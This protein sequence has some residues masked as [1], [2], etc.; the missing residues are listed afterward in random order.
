M[1]RDY[2]APVKL[3]Y[4]AQIYQVNAYTSMEQFDLAIEKL[5]SML[6]ESRYMDYFSQIEARIGD[7]YVNQN[8]NDFAARQY[9]FVLETYPKTEGS[10][11]AAFG[12]AQ[13]MEFYYQDPDSA[14][15]L[16][17][18]VQKEF[19]KTETV[20][21]AMQRAKVLQSYLKIRDNIKR[22]LADL[23]KL[24]A[25]EEVEM[26]IEE[27]TD[28]LSTDTLSTESVQE[29]LEEETKN[30][31]SSRSKRG[32]QAK[33]PPPAKKRTQEEVVQS[34]EKNRFS[35]AEYFL[36]NMQNY[37]SAEVAYIDFISATQDTVL[38]PKAYHTLYYIYLYQWEDYN[39]ADSLENI[40]LKQYPNSVYA[41]H[42]R[43]KKGNIIAVEEESNPYHE[44]YLEA[45]LRLFAD[46]FEDALN[47]Y[48]QIALEDSGSFWAERSRFAIAWIYEMKLKDVPKAIDAYA[49]IVKEYPN[50]EI[51]KIASNKI[52]EP[53]KDIE[54]NEDEGTTETDSTE[55]VNDIEQGGEDE[56]A[57]SDSTL[58][59]M[60]QNDSTEINQDTPQ[61]NNISPEKKN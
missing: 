40:I 17:L 44:L 52:K 60:E 5:Q 31:R 13:L 36:L 26:E 29:N 28:T 61:E 55:I 32:V 50:T 7:N 3:E 8:D 33:K 41:N 48:Y 22:D 18:R 39:K 25:G 35:L 19:R 46:N 16:Y 15:K 54:P 51:A 6:R 12:L 1:I 2:D 4:D 23:R 9:N 14:R 11:Q 59:I 43:E 57:K 58:I 56:S 45:E 47:I 38:K 24:E 27:S 49:A 10:S 34:L 21:E 30:I 42:I 37:D 53:P 20:E